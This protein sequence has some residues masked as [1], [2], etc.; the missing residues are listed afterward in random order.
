VG[1]AAWRR[2]RRPLYGLS[3]V[4][5]VGVAA[6]VVATLKLSVPGLVAG[7]LLLVVALVARWRMVTRHWVQVWI[8]AGGD[9][10]IVANVSQA[11]ADAAR[12]LFVGPLRRR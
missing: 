11:F 5:G 6:M 4:G 8:R 12:Q 1:D 7:A 10:I 2:L 9:D 3:V